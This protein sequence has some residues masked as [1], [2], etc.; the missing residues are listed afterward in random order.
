MKFKKILA[1]LLL[2]TIIIFSSGVV[3]ATNEDGLIKDNGDKEIILINVGE[4]EQRQIKYLSLTGIVKEIRDWDAAEGYKI[5]EVEDEAGGPANIIISDKTYILDCE[6][7][8]VGSVITG[9]YDAE[10]PMILIYP[11]QY[12]AEVIVVEREERNVKFD[13]FDKHLISSDNFLKLNITDETEIVLP[14][15]APYEGKLAD[16]KLI[17]IYGVAT[18]S[19]PAQTVPDKIIVLSKKGSEFFQTNNQNE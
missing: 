12:N 13:V 19:I 3:S 10:K 8:V 4:G 7:I 2:I 11:P 1:R 5:I 17:V 18:K 16:N 15:G 14:N 6:D 9:Y